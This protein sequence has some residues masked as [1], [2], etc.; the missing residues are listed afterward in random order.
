MSCAE[1]RGAAQN[2]TA[3]HAAATD[4]KDTKD[5]YLGA[6]NTSPEL[7]TYAAPDSP[8]GGTGI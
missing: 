7:Y 4:T 2:A 3:A 5:W 8:D 6:P 1:S